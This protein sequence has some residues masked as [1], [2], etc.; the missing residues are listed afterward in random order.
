MKKVILLMLVL[1]LLAIA[2]TTSEY[3]VFENVVLTAN[4]TEIKQF[5]EGMAAHNKKYHSDNEFGA[6]VHLIGNGANVGKY[7]WVMGPLPWSAFDNRPAGDGHDDD[8]NNNV[9][10]YTTGEAN[11]IYWKYK[12]DLSNFSK[13][14]TVKNLLVDF[15]NVKRFK[16]AQTMELLKN[17]KEVMVEKFPNENYGIYIN[18][19]PSTTEG[20]DVAFIS[21]FQKSAWLGEDPDFSKKYNEVHG[22]GSFKTF[23]KDWEDATEGVETELWI[24]QP[25]LGGIVDRVE[26]KTRQ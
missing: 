19:F 7:M 26:V 5:E 24:N 17:I 6:R 9:L 3:V 22:E 13:D 25:K 11:L 10:A 2:Q 21:F 12:A 15:Y 8:W 14:F 23:L 4:P 20:R 18:E 1:P 16:G